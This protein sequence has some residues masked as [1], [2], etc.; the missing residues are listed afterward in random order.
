MSAAAIWTS[1]LNPLTTV[2]YKC[3]CLKILANSSPVFFNRYHEVEKVSTGEKESWLELI[4]SLL[5]LTNMLKSRSY[6]SYD[7]FPLH[8]RVASCN[9][10]SIV[11][12]K[13]G[14]VCVGKFF[15]LFFDCTWSVVTKIGVFLMM[16]FS[17]SLSFT[18]SLTV[19]ISLTGFF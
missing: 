11:C 15:R 9:L 13:D 6:F 7:G 3:F 10:K 4:F 2:L 14:V 5:L 17:F 8:D 1:K 18:I 12:S 16:I 19:I